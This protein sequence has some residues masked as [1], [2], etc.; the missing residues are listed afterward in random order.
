ML[1]IKIAI[2]QPYFYPYLGYFKLIKS[3]DKFVFFNNVQYIRRGWV[4]RNRISNDFSLRDYA[5]GALL[6]GSQ[7]NGGGMW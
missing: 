1:N 5:S 2:Q 7:T 3:V 6:K 4:N